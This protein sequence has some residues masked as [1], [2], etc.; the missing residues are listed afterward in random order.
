LGGELG[1]VRPPHILAD[2]ERVYV[3]GDDGVTALSTQTGDVVWHSRGP[4]ERMLLS[5][6][7]LIATECGSSKALEANGHWV[8]ARAVADGG[9]VFKLRLPAELNDP[10]PI[11]EFGGLFV[12][13]DEGRAVLI[14]RDGRLRHQLDNTVLGGVRLGDDVVLL[15]GGKVARLAPS[16]TPRWSI[17][18]SGVD[19]DDGGIVS[20]PDGDLVEY[21]FGVVSDSG[22]RLKR[23]DPSDGATR[24]ETFCRP[25]GVAHKS[26][27]HFATVVLDADQLKVISRGSYGSFVEWL[28]PSTGRHIRRT[29]SK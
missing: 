21:D 26:Y 14:G 27:L 17:P 4:K 22:V 10:L 7:L 11:W 23:F 25:L 8:T 29:Q 9:E 20:L 18:S 12:V 19:T 28:D 15:M 5:A 13:E 2:S 3:A 6:E 1:G 24:W 16:G